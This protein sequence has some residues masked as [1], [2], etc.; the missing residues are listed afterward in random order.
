MHKHMDSKK[1]F[2]PVIACCSLLSVPRSVRMAESGR[3]NEFRNKDF[4]LGLTS[5]LG[6]SNY[7]T[8]FQFPLSLWS[9]FRDW[10]CAVR[11]FLC[12]F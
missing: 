9:V 12:G 2:G 10:V 7:G 4:W 11:P 3:V 6:R 5:S 8:V 1:C